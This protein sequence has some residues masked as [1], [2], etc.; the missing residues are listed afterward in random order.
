MVQAFQVV[1]AWVT[2]LL[3]RDQCSLDDKQ[4]Y[5]DERIAAEDGGTSPLEL[6]DLAAGLID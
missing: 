2:S 6:W 3:E 4:E 5:L 1:A